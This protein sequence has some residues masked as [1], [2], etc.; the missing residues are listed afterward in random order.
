M[1]A[2]VRPGH[3]TPLTRADNNWS[4]VAEVGT[5]QLEFRYLSFVTRDPKYRRAVDRAMKVLLRNHKLDGLA[6]IFV[7]ARTGQSVVRARCCAGADAAAF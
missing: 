7:D 1:I 2:T 6:P 3:P 4:S 5:L